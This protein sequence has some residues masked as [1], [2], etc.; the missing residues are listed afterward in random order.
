MTHRRQSIALLWLLL[1]FA[2]GTVVAT[3]GIRWA[4]D[5][6]AARAAAARFQVP[7]LIHFYGD[8]CLPCELVNARVFSDREVI[9]TLNKFFICV[10]VN[11]SAPEN[12]QLAAEYQVHSWPTDVFLAADGKVLYQ[13][14]S[15]TAKA[16]YLAILKNVAVMNRDRNV[17]L[18]SQQPPTQSSEDDYPRS[19]DPRT[20]SRT[21]YGQS[22]T[23]SPGAPNPTPQPSGSLV[24]QRPTVAG[25][26]RP[27]S[28]AWP[29]SPASSASLPG[30]LHM[31]ATDAKAVPARSAAF[32]QASV[33][34]DSS[35]LP[36]TNHPRESWQTNAASASPDASS[37]A[38]APRWKP[39]SFA[40]AQ[41]VTV[42]NPYAQ[43]E[44]DD[45]L[46]ASGSVAGTAA[47]AAAVPGNGASSGPPGTAL[48]PALNGYCPVALVT[49][50]KWVPGR[51]QYAV[52]HRGK[53]YF[54]QSSTAVEQFLAAPD[55]FAPVLSG[56]DPLV[57]LREG[58]LVPGQLQYGL[59]DQGSGRFFLFSSAGNKEA[60]WDDFDRLQMQL[61]QILTTSGL[62]P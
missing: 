51:Q 2:C 57:F 33:A 47:D 6:P 28:Q 3:E 39:A 7:L 32:A 49:A 19:A 14:V 52:R 59:Q 4:P 36:T 20:Q 56:Y 26:G 41:P 22:T 48:V 12:R 31:V 11:A 9:E 21:L 13:G 50:G 61:Q 23:P 60:F 5:L 44:A 8:H 62:T 37:T 53:L 34:G 55:R 35:G 25:D 54:M 10:Q 1:A 45:P 18:A 42:K 38:A 58:K 43:P 46:S 16:G 17:M 29:P 15:P 30:G 27:T 40:A 24:D